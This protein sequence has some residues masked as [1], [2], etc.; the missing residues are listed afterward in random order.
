MPVATS[1]KLTIALAAAVVAMAV[2]GAAAVLALER[3]G[4]AAGGHTVQLVVA[5]LVALAM[6]LALVAHRLLRRDIGAR[7]DGERALRA[8]EH[9]F[10]AVFDQAF[11]FTLLL[12]L[13]GEV[14]EVNDNTLAAAAASRASVVGRR[15]WD[16]PWWHPATVSTVQRAVAEASRGAFVRCE[17]T[18][19]G[20]ERGA[21]VLDLSFKPVRGETG[22]P[23]MLIGEGR[24]ITERKAAE[25][26]LRASEAKF[27]G[28]LA[29]AADA[30]IT[31]DEAQTI[32]LFNQG[33]EE[34]FHY[35]AKEAIGR[36]LEMLL[37]HRFRAAHGEHVA[38]FGRSGESARRMGARREIYGLRRGGEEFP[39]EA[40]IS[41]LETDGRRLFT[42]VLRD[43]TDRK[44]AADRQRFLA[45]A[46]ELLAASL[47]YEQT[48]EHVAN[49]AVPTLADACL[50]D[51]YSEEGLTG[52][53]V[54][55]R[56]PAKRELVAEM[57]RRYPPRLDGEHPLAAVRRSGTPIVVREVTDE[58]LAR[59]TRDAEH[60]NLVRRIGVASA[61]FVPLVA[62]GHVIGVVSCY[63]ESRRFDDDDLA[64]ALDLARRAALAIDH[65]RLY[66]GAR[67]ATEARDAVLGVVSHDLRN[68]LSTIAMCS[69]ALLDPAPAPHGAVRSMA[70]TI[71]QSA[72][73]MQRIIRDLLDVTSIEAGHLSLDRHPVEPAELL[74]AARE[75]LWVQASEAGLE[76]VVQCAE[77]LPP[78]DADRERILQVLFNLVGNA[79]KFTDR[80]GRIALAATPAPAPGN[81]APPPGDGALRGAVRFSVRDTGR[82][83]PAE[84][85]P[86]VFDRFW[87]VEK[88]R[89]GGA[90]LGLAIAKGIVEAHGGNLELESAPG[91]GTTFSFTIAACAPAARSGADTAPP[92]PSASTASGGRGRP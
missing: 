14:L 66:E 24:D 12:T 81:G 49:A 56:D 51:V 21:M 45:E 11:Q 30:I 83:I 90:G 82:G 18:M 67:R 85:L 22:E 86:H 36:P 57:R 75:M 29:I 50:V 6:A 68:P 23:T 5:V 38:R 88:T 72:E 15:L 80:G 37:P 32:V 9:R 39:A 55:H 59:T 64:L 54:A 4:E 60:R 40:S 25:A 16:L 3:A 34:I 74:A 53:A 47:D 2:A 43:V 48:L 63:A 42:V 26:A 31:V 70:A 71:R 62:R 87:Q 89:R 84:H 41:Q 35:P 7:I 65:A 8:S 78:V 69:A 33:A 58:L 92:P 46:G 17:G 79:I 10:H 28:I 1:R 76:I 27:A 13:D 20:A 91:V 44:R 77:G 73:W 61:M 52:I 19:H